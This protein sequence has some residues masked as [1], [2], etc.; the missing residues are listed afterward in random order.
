MDLNLTFFFLQKK[1]NTLQKINFIF[2]N[3]LILWILFFVYKPWQVWKIG[4]KNPEPIKNFI[5][6]YD[7]DSNSEILTS[8][9]IVQSNVSVYLNNY[10]DQWRAYKYYF[11]NSGALS[12]LN[13]KIYF[14]KVDIIN[15]SNSNDDPSV[16]S[17]QW[18]II[19]SLQ[20]PIQDYFLYIENLDQFTYQFNTNNYLPLVCVLNNF[21]LVKPLKFRNIPNQFGN[22]SPLKP[23]KNEQEIYNNWEFIGVTTNLNNKTMIY[24]LVTQIGDEQPVTNTALNPITIVNN[25]ATIEVVDH[26]FRTG[27][28]VLLIDVNANINGAHQIS[29]VTEDTFSFFIGISDTTYTPGVGAKVV[30]TAGC[31]GFDLAPRQT[32]KLEFNL[33][34]DDRSADKLNYG[35]IIVT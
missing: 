21:S 22:F 8:N 18:E 20:N 26:Q 30:L 13:N 14:V 25:I 4:F 19:P 12:A 1:M 29:V 28:W 34:I 7:G 24:D 35:S 27:Q 17:A 6:N 33:A 10:Y 11:K 9:M 5:I 31:I 32:V 3:I 23:N 15:A 2:L 16:D